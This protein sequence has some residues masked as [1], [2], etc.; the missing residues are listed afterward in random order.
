MVFSK[1]SITVIPTLSIWSEYIVGERRVVCLENSTPPN[2][3]GSREKMFI[4]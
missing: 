4:N 1:M 3:T 2:E